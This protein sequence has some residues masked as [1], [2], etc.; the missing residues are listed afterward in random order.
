MVHIVLNEM[1]PWLLSVGVD[2]ALECVLD[3]YGLVWEE[4]GILKKC[5]WSKVTAKLDSLPSLNSLLLF[6]SPPTFSLCCYS[7]HSPFPLFFF[8]PFISTFFVLCL[9]SLGKTVLKK[10]VKF[11]LSIF[12]SPSVNSRSSSPEQSTELATTAYSV[13]FHL[14]AGKPYANTHTHTHTHT[15]IRTHTPG[16]VYLQMELAQ[17][18]SGPMHA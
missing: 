12:P 2:N 10:K 5:F 13:V 8:S 7:T 11:L 3:E 4:F 9:F 16:Q 6:L 15:H 17:I 14:T 18:L 1:F